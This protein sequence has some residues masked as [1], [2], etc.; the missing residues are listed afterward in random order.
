MNRVPFAK[1]EYYHIYNRG[2]NKMEIFNLE[3]DYV[4]FQELLYVL[5][6]R[7]TQKHSDVSPGRTWTVERGETLVDIGSYTLMPNHF[8]VLIKV[9]E[10]KDASLF[11]Q[12]LLTSHSMYF[13]KKYDRTGSLFQGKSKSRH[14]NID[15]YLKYIFSYIHLN[16][17]KLFKQN[18]KEE[19]IGDVEK[20]LE[21][22]DNYKYSSYP[23]Y[24]GI[25]R[26]ENA[27]LN[28]GVFPEYFTNPKKHIDELLEWLTYNKNET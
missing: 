18:W 15:R 3:K 27:I 21:F 25:I 4:R 6:S 14:A 24:A 22:L 8:H 26:P 5:N 28:K 12:R 9:K 10:E 1:D 13:N 17:I 20:A 11:L 7:E 2:T 16:I 23:D 19:G